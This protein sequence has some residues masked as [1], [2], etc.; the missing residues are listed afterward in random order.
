MTAAFNTLW[1]LDLRTVGAMAR[2]NMLVRSQC[3]RCGALMR[4]EVADL[5]ARHGEGW[6]VIDRQE[7]F[8]MVACD[9]AAFYLAAR[10]YGAPWRILLEDEGLRETLADAPTPVTARMLVNDNKQ[11]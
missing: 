4:V 1:P 7:R 11:R 2:R 9:G 10:T 3:R 5:V 6:S 8:R